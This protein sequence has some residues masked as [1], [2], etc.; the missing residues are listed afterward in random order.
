MLPPPVTLNTKTGWMDVSFWLICCDDALGSM[1][2][3]TN[4]AAVLY[5]CCQLAVM[6]CRLKHT[7]VEMETYGP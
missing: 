1:S 6:Y 3:S 7:T 5:C 2:L 4:A